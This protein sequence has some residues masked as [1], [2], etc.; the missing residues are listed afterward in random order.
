MDLASL[1][2]T[3]CTGTCQKSKARPPSSGKTRPN[4]NADIMPTHTVE[5]QQ[6]SSALLFC[7]LLLLPSSIVDHDA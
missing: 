2:R 4:G 7:F 1:Y 6:P 5:T 3:V